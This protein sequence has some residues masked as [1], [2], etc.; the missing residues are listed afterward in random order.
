MAGSSI[1]TNA[2]AK[3]V[4]SKRSL[5]IAGL[6]LLL[7]IVAFVS[8]FIDISQLKT[9]YD[10]LL[11]GKEPDEK[12]DEPKPDEVIPETNGDGKET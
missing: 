2:L 6:G 7:V 9:A 12:S 4:M 8:F 3:S 10:D 5:I 1:F 11:N